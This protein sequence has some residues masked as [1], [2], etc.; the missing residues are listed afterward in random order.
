MV[1]LLSWLWEVVAPTQSG[2]Q[3]PHQLHH[4][5]YHHSHQSR[6]TF[7]LFFDP[8]LHLLLEPS[9]KS[10]AE[11][12]RDS[13]GTWK[14]WHLKPQNICHT[15]NWRIQIIFLLKLLNQTSKKQNHLVAYY[16]NCDYVILIGVTTS[17]VMINQSQ[18]NYYSQL[19]HKWER[20]DFPSTYLSLVFGHP[21]FLIFEC[22]PKPN[23]ECSDIII[24]AQIRWQRYWSFLLNTI[25]S[26][27]PL[28]GLL[29]S[30]S[31]CKDLWCNAFYNS[32]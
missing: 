15:D 31:S 13:G 21:S 27:I 7:Q 16:M 2:V 9:Q 1:T 25:T 23:R 12:V 24:I 14:L 8:H 4:H 19:F 11:M 29:P 17:H 20:A 32:S 26:S 10:K 18:Q 28:Q 30:S 3:S 22:P 6:L 5:C